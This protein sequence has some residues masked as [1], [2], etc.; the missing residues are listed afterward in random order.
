M[1]NVDT[2]DSAEFKG[3]VFPSNFDVTVMGSVLMTTS[4][5]STGISFEELISIPVI[6]PSLCSS[7][8]TKVLRYIFPTFD[9]EV[10][11]YSNK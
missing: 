3:N 5:L 1:A 7:P 10:F 8:D 4:S 11:I 2:S 6:F 9:E